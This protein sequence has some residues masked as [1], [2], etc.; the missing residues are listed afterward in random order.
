[1][2]E[3]IIV[4]FTTLDIYSSRPHPPPT[5]FSNAG[6]MASN[7]P[8]DREHRHDERDTNDITP[9]LGSDLPLLDD[10]LQIFND[11]RKKHT[12]MMDSFDKKKLSLSTKNGD[13]LVEY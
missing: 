5:Y 2:K 1:M 9:I 7:R 13:G 8:R 3:I 12:I 10:L 11:T 4:I 6:T